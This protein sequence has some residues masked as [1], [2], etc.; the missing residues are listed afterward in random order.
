MG[1]TQAGKDLLA[2]LRMVLAHLTRGFSFIIAPH[3][4]GTAVTFNLPGKLTVVLAVVVVAFVAGLA[5]V[6]VT[7]TRLAIL[8]LETE[9]LETENEMLRI[10]NEKISQIEQEIARIDQVRRQI[11]A[12]AGV[13]PGEMAEAASFGDLAIA[14]NVWPRRYTYAL[15][16]PFHLQRTGY[17]LG[18]LVP[19]T[20]WISR[21]FIS[22]STDRPVH[23]GIDIAAS[24]GTPVRCAQDGFVESA[25]WDKIYGNRIVVEHDDSLKTVY[26]HNERILVKEG[27]HVVK[28]QVI[29]TVGN[30]GRSTAPHLHF[31]VLKHDQPVDPELYV[32]FTTK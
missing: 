10:E 26:G 21:R 13:L 27:D 32:D 19:A 11:E 28:G 14:P 30:T 18:M 31:E 29:A 12:W 5:F 6:G 4:T 23:P 22:E 8:A 3:G 15:L 17:P 7:Y 16:R 20:G 25:G 2:K 1:Y 24:T 9:R